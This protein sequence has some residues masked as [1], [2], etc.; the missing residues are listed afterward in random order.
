[1]LEVSLLAATK[2]YGGFSQ[3]AR[4]RGIMRGLTRRL[5][6]TRSEMIGSQLFMIQSL[7]VGLQMVLRNVVS[8]FSV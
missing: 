6:S 4:P 8:D 7:N 3:V 5:P 1:M 2:L